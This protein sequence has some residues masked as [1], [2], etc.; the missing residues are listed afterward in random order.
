[1]GNGKEDQWRGWVCSFTVSSS[2]SL[3]GECV[4]KR[5]R[6][7]F[8]ESLKVGETGILSPAWK[9]VQEPREKG[10][11]GVTGRLG[12]RRRL[13]PGR[14]PRGP[15]LDGGRGAQAAG[16]LGVAE[17]KWERRVSWPTVAPSTEIRPGSG[18]SARGPQAEPPSAGPVEASTRSQEPAALLAHERGPPPPRRARNALPLRANSKP[19][20]TVGCL[21]WE[22][23]ELT[24]MRRWLTKKGWE[25]RESAWDVI[26]GGTYQLEKGKG[27]CPQSSWWQLFEKL[28]TSHVYA[29]LMNWVTQAQ[30][31]LL[32]QLSQLGCWCQQAALLVG[33]PQV[34]I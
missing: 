22:G 1:M 15:E 14:G 5:F 20:V 17:A 3:R 18:T 33:R 32:L 24:E 30:A 25:V 4:S 19:R 10:R 31:G 29:L 8:R 21:L 26:T 2:Q 7:E 16:L 34:S 6:S 23:R 11:E 13:H 27:G 9:R 28:K 12:V